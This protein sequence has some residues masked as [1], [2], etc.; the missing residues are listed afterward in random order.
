[1]WGS[2]QLA[3]R[4]L[5]TRCCQLPFVSCYVSANAVLHQTDFLTRSRRLVNAHQYFHITHAFF[6]GDV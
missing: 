6:T 5:T 1:M 4:Q 2:W 3:K